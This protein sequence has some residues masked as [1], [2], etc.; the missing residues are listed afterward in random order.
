MNAISLLRQWLVNEIAAE[1]LNASEYYA[2]RE[3]S[4]HRLS[5][6]SDV[7]DKLDA[8]TG[9]TDVKYDNHYRNESIVAETWTK[10]RPTEEGMY[11]YCD[12]HMCPDPVMVGHYPKSGI[13]VIG[14]D[15]ETPEDEAWW[16]PA[17]VPAKPV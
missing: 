14:F 9:Q 11:W 12:N 10:E 7:I 5:A 15:S 8:L 13:I 1:T 3:L 4:L 17:F 6:L 2:D 16:M